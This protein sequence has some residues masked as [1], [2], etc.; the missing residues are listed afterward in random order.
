[1][2]VFA[3]DRLKLLLKVSDNIIEMI[4]TNVFSRVAGLSVTVAKSRSEISR[5]VT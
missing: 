1:M 4:P 3:T 2:F 5:E